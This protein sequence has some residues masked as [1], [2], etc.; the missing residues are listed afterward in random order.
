M[1]TLSVCCRETSP[2]RPYK[3]CSSNPFTV[4]VLTEHGGHCAH[5]P[6]GSWLTG[7]A[8][9]DTV[10]M[11]FFSAVLTCMGKPGASA[12]AIAA[13][14]KETCEEATVD[15]NQAGASAG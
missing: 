5:L 9:M 1:V 2:P 7:K 4:F 14:V 12:S 11:Q 6:L 13:C 8:W 3:E 15:S 10:A